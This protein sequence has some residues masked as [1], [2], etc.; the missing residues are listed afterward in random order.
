MRTILFL[1]LLIP[2]IVLSQCAGVQ[3]AT[4]SPLPVN[5]NYEPGTVVTMCY[6]MDGWNGTNFG[7]NWV[8]GFGI[9][10][11]PGWVSYSPVTPS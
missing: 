6:T 1:L 9:N 5:G 11:G 3:S 7:A 10:L 4:L 2:N 8:E